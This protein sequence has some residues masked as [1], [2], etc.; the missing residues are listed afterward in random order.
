VETS[1]LRGRILN[2]AIAADLVLEEELADALAAFYRLLRH[3][4]RRIN[5]TALEDSDEAIDRLLIEPVAAARYLP[6]GGSLMDIGS[7][8]GSPAIPLALAISASELVMV[9]SKSRKAAFL[10]EA[11]RELGIESGRVEEQRFE[12]LSAAAE[13]Q[14]RM[15]L[16]SIR[17]V[18]VAA[19]TLESL[20]EFLSP[21]GLLA[22]FRGA[23]QSGLPEG[24]QGLT[25]VGDH[26]LV[27]ALGSSLVVLRREG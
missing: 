14:R 19:E 5:L 3:W 11:L 6:A 12:R 2:R 7:G 10:R 24:L 15:S 8:G 21:E 1:D 23:T 16:V 25:V 4:N 22:L 26:S 18:Q 20:R 9:E 27:P 17:A 13:Y